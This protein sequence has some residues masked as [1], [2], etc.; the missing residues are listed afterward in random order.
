MGLFIVPWGK[1]ISPSVQ[2]DSDRQ[3]YRPNR[4]KYAATEDNLND[5]K[6]FVTD[7]DVA[8]MKAAGRR[9]RGWAV[10]YAGR[11]HGRGPQ[12]TGI[13]GSGRLLG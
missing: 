12:G 7:A 8:Y 1:D 10:L 3:S 9:C 6:G 5:H 11:L 13:C 2:A 4:I